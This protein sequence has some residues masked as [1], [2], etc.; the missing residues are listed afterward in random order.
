[1]VHRPVNAQQYGAC[2][3]LLLP[4]GKPACLS[5][6][7][8]TAQTAPCSR[9]IPYNHDLRRGHRAPDAIAAAL[10]KR[11]FV[12]ATP[13]LVT[14]ARTHPP[15]KTGA[16]A[17]VPAVRRHSER[18][19]SELFLEAAAQAARSNK[20]PAGGNSA[21][22]ERGP[23][24]G[25]R[26]VQSLAERFKEMRHTVTARLTCGAWTL[27]I[28]QGVSRVLT[29]LGISSPCSKTCYSNVMQQWSAK[30]L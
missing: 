14:T 3:Y 8:L 27:L 20:V 4:D 19:P 24:P 13:Y 28:R 2:P 1:M 16:A 26:A 18:Q 12:R 9:C 23:A 5:A 7:V 22:D 6:G 30:R 15:A 21:A 25:G 17:A 11:A 29:M 10:A